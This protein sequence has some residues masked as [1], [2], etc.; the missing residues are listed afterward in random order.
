M[1]IEYKT[2]SLELKADDSGAIEGYASTFGNV[3][4]GGDVVEKGAFKKTIKELKGGKLLILA[5]HNPMTPI[6]TNES[7]IEDDKGLYVK[8]QINMKDPFAVGRYELTKMAI[9]RGIPMGLSIGYQTITAMPDKENPR[10][11]RLKELKLWEYS[12]VTFPMNQEAMI[13][14]AK[15]WAGALSVKDLI[16]KGRELGL[17]PSELIEAIKSYSAP[18]DPHAEDPRLLAQS[19]DRLHR[20]L[21]K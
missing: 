18:S 10:V 14:A 3:D 19:L 7:A 8:G 1:S 17:T 20:A 12:I 6:G 15:S 5:D 21:T 4:Q 9:A 13:T 11:R 2:F 16:N